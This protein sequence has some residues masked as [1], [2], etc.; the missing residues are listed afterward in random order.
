MKY[1][2]F[3]YRVGWVH[4]RHLLIWQHGIFRF[5]L[6]ALSNRANQVLI[7]RT[8][9]PAISRTVAEYQ[10]RLMLYVM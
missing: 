3:E 8:D 1:K 2:R 5:K 7:Y 10:Q 4:T 9:P 6:F